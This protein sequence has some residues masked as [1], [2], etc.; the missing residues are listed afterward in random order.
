MFINDHIQSS[1][2][3]HYCSSALA[4]MSGLTMLRMCN[5]GA[6]SPDGEH[7]Y[8]NQNSTATFCASVHTLAY[9]QR[10]ELSCT[11]LWAR[12]AIPTVPFAH[13]GASLDPL[14][15]CLTGQGSR[16]S[17]RHTY[18]PSDCAGQTRGLQGQAIQGSRIFR[19]ALR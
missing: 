12:H 1:Q 2:F 17:D 9:S 16:Q 4:L 7:R 10:H 14:A 8:T 18:R 3:L 6:F 13:R 5:I 11:P 19:T 15:P